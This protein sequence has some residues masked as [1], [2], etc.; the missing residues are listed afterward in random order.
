MA[1]F[2]FIGDPRHNGQGP[3]GEGSEVMTAFGL[4][5]PQGESVE[6]EDEATARK[7]RGNSHFKEHTG[8][9][10]GLTGRQGP[11]PTAEARAKAEAEAKARAAAD[12]LQAIAKAQARDRERDEARAKAESEE[13]ARQAAEAEARAK[14]EAEAAGINQ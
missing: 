14:A 8:L 9:L 6:V 3:Q 1:T 7:L 12:R 2:A 5:F 11:F 10:A 4:S 13:R